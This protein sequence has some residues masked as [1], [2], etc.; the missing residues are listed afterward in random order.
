MPFPVLNVDFGLGFEDNR[1][2]SD[3]MELLKSTARWEAIIILIALSAVTLW[4]LA[5]LRSFDGLLH[6]GDGNFSPAR[7]QLLMVTVL[8]AMQYVFTALTAHDRSKMPAVPDGLVGGL[9]GSQLVY[10]GAKALRLIGTSN[11]RER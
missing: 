6:D 10:L 11:S 3:L 8:T 9:G 7:V 2:H 5:R 1:L 4:K